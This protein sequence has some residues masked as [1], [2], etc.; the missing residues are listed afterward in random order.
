M[1]ARTTTKDGSISDATMLNGG[2]PWATGDT[3]TYSHN[4]TI[5]IDIDAGVGGA[6]GTTAIAASSSVTGKALTVNSGVRVICRGNL[7]LAS[8]HN[9]TTTL[10][11]NG[12]ISM[13]PPSGATYVLNMTYVC[14]ITG[15]GTF[16][17][18]LSGGGGAPYMV[19]NN[20]RAQ[21]LSNADGMSITDW[22]DSTHYGGLSR[23][24]Q[25]GIASFVVQNC[26]FTR[27]SYQFTDPDS[28]TD[29]NLTF[30]NNRFYSSVAVPGGGTSTSAVWFDFGTT[31][32][33]GVRVIDGNSCDLGITCQNLKL[34]SG[35]GQFTNNAFIGGDS[36]F[37]TGC[38]WA[39]KSQFDG[40]YFSQDSD[41]RTIYGPVGA[42]YFIHP[43]ATNAH[44]LIVASNRV[45]VVP[46][47][48]QCLVR[49]PI[50][51]SHP[52]NKPGAGL[53]DKGRV[54][55]KQSQC[56]SRASVSAKACSPRS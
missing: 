1:A 47:V 53:S 29:S 30:Q 34:R 20:G 46:G 13:I 24:R 38:T 7:N 21:G 31:G 26:T 12:R 15:S 22:G 17:A 16:D 48:F 45:A 33:N 9:G 19:S 23:G 49:N 8:S 32:T 18:D 3:L 5:D 51:V 52:S 27:S 2:A 56:P 4:I 37:H 41:S 11:N 42:N 28:D 14:Q 39:T 25:T 43:A 54:G 40:N 50:T 55:Q 6:T 44:L 35:G 10:T 36:Y